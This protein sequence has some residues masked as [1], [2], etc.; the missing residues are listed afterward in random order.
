MAVWDAVTVVAGEVC[1][2]EVV[3]GIASLATDPVQAYEAVWDA[4]VAGEVCRIEV[5]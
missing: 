1:R 3:C 5:V 4:V 2:I